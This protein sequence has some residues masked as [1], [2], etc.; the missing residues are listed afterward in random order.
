MKMSLTD[1]ILHRVIAV[2]TEI[3]Y[4]TESLWIIEEYPSRELLYKGVPS[5][6]T[7]K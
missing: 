2:L 4:Q 6:H 3:G 5:H 1:I 7:P